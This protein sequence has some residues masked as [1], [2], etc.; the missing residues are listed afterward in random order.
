MDDDSDD[1][2]DEEDDEID[3]ETVRELYK[4]LKGSVRRQH[5]NS[6]PLHNNVVHFNVYVLLFRRKV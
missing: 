6:F 4:A 5:E 1:Q 2:G 3:E